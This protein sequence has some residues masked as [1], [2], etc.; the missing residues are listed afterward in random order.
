LR[1]VPPL[2]KSNLKTKKPVKRGAVHGCA[3]PYNCGAYFGSLPLQ[4]SPGGIGLP[5]DTSWM[6]EKTTDALIQLR[7]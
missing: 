5:W 6:P 7:A 2:H 4:Q 1:K 3:V